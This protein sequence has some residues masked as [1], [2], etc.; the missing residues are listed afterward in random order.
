[1]ATLADWTPDTFTHE[2]STHP[3]W[4]RGEG[5][6][7][8]VIHEMPG[9]IPEVVEFGEEVV[10]AGHTVVLPQLFG[11]PEAPMGLPALARTVPRICISREI[12]AF[13]TGRT[14]PVAIWLRALARSLHAEFGGRGVGALGMCFTGGFALAMAVDPAVAAPVVAQPS[15]PF[16]ITARRRADLGLSP[17]DLAAVR[18]R[19]DEGCRVLGVQYA[20]DPATGAR[21]DTLDAELGDAFIRVDLPGK[22]HSTLT[23]QRSQTAVDAVL[24]FFAEQLDPS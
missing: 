4:R 16:P 20:S 3:T 15:L 2:Q 13:R 14:S 1:M 11:V 6:P 22:G 19:T 9:I 24:A 8:I 17:A 23:L 18:R 5:S 12:I 10:E 7:V 21:F